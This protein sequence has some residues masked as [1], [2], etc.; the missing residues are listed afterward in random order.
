MSTAADRAQRR[1]QDRQARIIEERKKD[2]QKYRDTI[3]ERLD[4]FQKE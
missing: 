4:G 3:R 1:E 2:I